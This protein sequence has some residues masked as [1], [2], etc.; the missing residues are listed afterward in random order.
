MLN[1]LRFSDQTLNTTGLMECIIDERYSLLFEK[2]LTFRFLNKNT[3]KLR[4]LMMY[5]NSNLTLLTVRT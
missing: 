5:V 1:A 2:L 3:E 4:I